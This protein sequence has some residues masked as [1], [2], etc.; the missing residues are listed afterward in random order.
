MPAA[1]RPTGNAADAP[2]EPPAPSAAAS[3]QTPEPKFVTTSGAK[4]LDETHAPLGRYTPVSL[5]EPHQ[6]G[7][8]RLQSV[9]SILADDMIAASS[10]RGT[11]VSQFRTHS[12]SSRTPNAGVR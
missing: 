11:S 3:S 10:Q 7:Y 9:D 6:I 12:W 4:K 8:A 1:R 2:P 5:G